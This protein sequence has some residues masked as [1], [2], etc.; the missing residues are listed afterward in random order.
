MAGVAEMTIGVAAAA[1]GTVWAPGAS[2]ADLIERLRIRTDELDASI[3]QL[4]EDA[5]RDHRE[6]TD[7]LETVRQE[8]SVKLR[9]LRSELQ[10][11]EGTTVRIDGVGFPVIAA[12]FVLTGMPEAWV[13]V[14][15]GAGLLL[16]F[17]AAFTTA[18]AVHVLRLRQAGATS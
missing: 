5:S 11:R 1:I 13:R 4:R 18:G 16:A 10:A 14:P 6:L 2:V 15:R 3:R 9:T 7:E 12:S 8:L 17:A